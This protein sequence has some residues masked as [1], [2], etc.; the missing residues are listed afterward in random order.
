M[1]SRL[2]LNSRQS[3]CLNLLGVQACNLTLALEQGLAG[4]ASEFRVTDCFFPVIFKCLHFLMKAFL[5]SQ[6]LDAFIHFLNK[7]LSGTKMAQ[8]LWVLADLLGPISSSQYPC[9]DAHKCLELQLQKMGLAPSSGLLEHPYTCAH[10][11][12]HRHLCKNK[13]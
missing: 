9:Q 1:H 13:S 8:G 7:S 6:M 12:T 4:P 11:F 5:N 10:S 2:D 3:F